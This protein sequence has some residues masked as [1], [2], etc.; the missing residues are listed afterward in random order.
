MYL[1]AAR[2]ASKRGMAQEA[3]GQ[4]MKTR[5]L[6]SSIAGI[7]FYAWAGIAGDPIGT[8]Y[9]SARVDSM[10]QYME[11]N[12]A[13]TQS[14]EYH[15]Q[16]KAS[17]EALEGP[18]DMAL[19]QV[20]SVAGDMGDEPQPIVVVSTASA[21]P[22]RQ[23]DAIAWGIDMNEHTTEL[24]GQNGIFTMAT[25]GAFSELSWIQGHDDGA[26]IDRFLEALLSDEGYRERMAGT[27]DLFVAGSGRRIIMAK[28]P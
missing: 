11:V 16:V 25:V 23:G 5:D 7:P 9:L 12:G 4:M 18:A 20:L 3:A 10:E 24:T 27:G 14:A 28:L 2:V 22:G 21:A 8:Y 6:V 19:G 15:L 13:V 1:F 17:A 26:S